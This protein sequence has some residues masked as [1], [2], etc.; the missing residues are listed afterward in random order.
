MSRRR[1]FTVDFTTRVALDALHGDQTTHKVHPNQVSTWKRQATDLGATFSNGS[2]KAR[3]DHQG[4][5]TTS[6]PASR[7]RMA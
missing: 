1:R 2:D 4:I 6:S 5:G 7:C 3:V